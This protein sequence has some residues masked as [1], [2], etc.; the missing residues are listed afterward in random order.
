MASATDLS[1]AEDLVQ[2]IA[3]SPSPYHAAAHVADRLRAAGFVQLQ[4]HE[5]WQLE[6]GSRAFV[7][8]GGASI[9]AFE[10]GAR[11]P[12]E[13]GFLCVGAHTDSPN[14]RVKPNALGSSVGFTQLAVEVYGGV[15]LHT[16]LDRDL[17]LAGRVVLNGGQV[18][19]VS[20]DRALCRIPNLAIHLQREV[21][22][23]GVIINPQQHLVPVLGYDEGSET[24]FSE[25]LREQLSGAAGVASYDLCLYDLSPPV[26]A[27]PGREWIY[28]ARLDNL[29][30]CHA[31]IAALLGAGKVGDVTRVV[32]LYDH[33]ECG[34]QS[35]A[36]AR[37]R[38][39]YSVLERIG[40]AFGSGSARSARAFAR[41]LLVSADMAHGVHPNYAD[42]HEKQHQPKLGGGP[43]IKVNV[44]QSY[45]TDSVSAAVF[46]EACE[47]A[48]VRPQQFVSRNDMP[49]GSTIGP[50]TAARV[51][52]RAVDVGNPMLSM[53]S[54]REMAA[55]KDVAPMIEVLTRLFR[56]HSL[57]DASW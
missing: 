8:R 38:F 31:A 19:L 43:V 9:V 46:R 27:G 11:P 18:R 34:S 32:A 47:E 10:V 52:M 53:H 16:W 12:A 49:C 26:I 17:A 42:R 45:S 37:S 54:C 24:A 35:A 20:Y 3:A 44:N 4:E 2:F 30:S 51:G 40:E 7:I 56:R 15:L 48:N 6:A 55:T 33:E 29:A 23:Q 25:L 13:A 1:A 39:F 14:L 50:I 28:A 57:P 22:S 41:S 21:N 36:G 5:D